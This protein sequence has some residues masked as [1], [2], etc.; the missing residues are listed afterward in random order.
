MH[1][2]EKQLLTA[3]LSETVFKACGRAMIT[4]GA[5]PRE[6]VWWVG[7]DLVAKLSLNH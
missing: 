1:K 5:T 4:E 6:P 2:D 3:R 7:H